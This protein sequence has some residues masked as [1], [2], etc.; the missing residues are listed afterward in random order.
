MS[1]SK[2]VGCVQQTCLC[3][4]FP[5][6]AYEHTETEIVELLEEQHKK[7]DPVSISFKLKCSLPLTHSAFRIFPRAHTPW[8][9]FVAFDTDH[10][11]LVYTHRH[12]QQECH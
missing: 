7:K 9:S 3:L 4:E 11:C 1:L 2:G 12:E 6:M 5:A 10:T 8:N